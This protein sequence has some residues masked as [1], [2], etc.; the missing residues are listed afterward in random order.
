MKSASKIIVF[1]F[2]QIFLFP[3]MVFFVQFLIDYYLL[4]LSEPFRRPTWLGMVIMLMGPY[5][6][7]YSKWANNNI[8]NR[9]TSKPVESIKPKPTKSSKTDNSSSEHIKINKRFFNAILIVLGALPIFYIGY[10]FTGNSLDSSSRAIIKEAKACMDQFPYMNWF[11]VRNGYS[12]GNSHRTKIVENLK[13]ALRDPEKY[14]GNVPYLDCEYSTMS[15]DKI[16]YPSAAQYAMRGRAKMDLEY[17]DGAMEDFNKALETDDA[18]I[19]TYFLRGNLK[20]FTGDRNGA[21]EDWTY[22]A[23]RIQSLKNHIVHKLVEEKCN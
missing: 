2:F 7:T 5:F 22:Y 8:W 19:L 23:G 20:E 12:L 11:Y 13:R 14:K 4:G 17:Y 15:N 1:L 21:C 18:Y 6:F 3:I 10:N 16:Y 9:K